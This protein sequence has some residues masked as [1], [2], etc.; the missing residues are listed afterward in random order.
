MG[1]LSKLIDFLIPT[2]LSEP[3]LETSPQTM[4]LKTPSQ[5]ASEKLFSQPSL[6]SEQ[7]QSSIQ[8]MD[9]CRVERLA[10]LRAKRARHEA[11]AQYQQYAL[12]PHNIYNPVLNHDGLEWTA[13]FG[14]DENNQPLLVGRGDCPATALIDFSNKWLGVNERS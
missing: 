13:S 5:K 1:L 9:S 12:M 8:Y 14:L 2:P 4:P 7:E 10:I 6:Q 11:I 3:N